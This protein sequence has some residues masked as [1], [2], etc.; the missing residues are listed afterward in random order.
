MKL[1]EFDQIMKHRK[2]R[3]LKKSAE[4]FETFIVGIEGCILENRDDILENTALESMIESRSILDY[5]FNDLKEHYPN[6]VKVVK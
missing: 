5:A 2:M 3:S 6:A 1:I 4:D